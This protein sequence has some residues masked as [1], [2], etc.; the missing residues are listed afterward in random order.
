M[1]KKNSVQLKLCNV[2]NYIYEDTYLACIQHYQMKRVVSGE[3][4]CVFMQLTALK[5]DGIEKKGSKHHI[6]EL[7]ARTTNQPST[8]N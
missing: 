3:C 4:A 8:N 1:K 5:P 2:L 7:L 6:S